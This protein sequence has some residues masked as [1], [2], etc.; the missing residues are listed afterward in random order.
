VVLKYLTV[1]QADI[2][3]GLVKAY[4]WILFVILFVAAV[5]PASAQQRVIVR[6]QLGLQG[7]QFTCLVLN[8]NV[9]Y[10]LGDPSGELFLITVDDSVNLGSLLTLLSNQ[11]GIVDAEVDQQLFLIGAAAGP[12]PESLLDNTPIPYYGAPVWDGYVNQPAS[13]IVRVQQAQ[14]TF[15]VTG[16]GVVAMIDTGVDTQHPALVPVLVPGYNFINNTPSGNETG[17]LN[18]SSAALLDG[19]SPEP[20]Y[21]NSSTIALVNESSAALLDGGGYSDFGHG[22]M[23]AGIVHLVAP[24]AQIMPLKAF[25]ADGSGYVSN[26]IRATYYAVKNGGKVISMSF[27]FS[28]SSKEM[29][30]AVNYASSQGL[31]CVASAGNNGEDVVVYPAGLKN[32]MGV[33]S[34][35]DYGTR[36]SFSNYGP[37][38]WVAAPGEGIVS[39]YPYGTYS[40][41]WGTSFS[42][43]FVSGTAALLV[44]LSANANQQSAAAAIAHANWI[45]SDMGNGQLDIYQAVQS[46]VTTTGQQ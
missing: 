40:A 18:E 9:A 11:F 46:W 32:V 15:N 2:L 6:D 12:I 44:G 30:R 7:L 29:A 13:Q 36:S 17:D 19:G 43:P 41:G 1:R 38:V 31:I 27:S 37:D 23:T 16:A 26:I 20:T 21:V 3:E 39:T 35:S 8:C 42:A 28:P 22:T 24:T 45:S 33:A 10:N 25:A 5:L 14:N 4:R 34:T